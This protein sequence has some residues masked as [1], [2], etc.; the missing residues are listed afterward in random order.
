M[1]LQQ[2]ILSYFQGL[3]F[4]IATMDF[5][6]LKSGEAMFV[7]SATTGYLEYQDFSKMSVGTDAMQNEAHIFLNIPKI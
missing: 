1:N 6:Q 5:H 7:I 2:Q 4:S 3:N